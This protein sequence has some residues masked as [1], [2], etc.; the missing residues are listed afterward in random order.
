MELGQQVSRRKMQLK[1]ARLESTK[2]PRESELQESVIA[3]RTADRCH[4]YVGS[5]Q[6]HVVD[7]FCT[8]HMLVISSI[9][10]L[11]CNVKNS[12]R[13]FTDKDVLKRKSR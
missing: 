4:M 12:L 11:S 6:R 10:S 1:E 8:M 2:N 5:L 9:F 3:M 7:R 13:C